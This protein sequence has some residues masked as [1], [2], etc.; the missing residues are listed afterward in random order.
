MGASGDASGSSPRHSASAARTASRTRPCVPQSSPGSSAPAL[1]GRALGLL[2]G[3]GGSLSYVVVVV[4]S[5]FALSFVPWVGTPHHHHLPAVSSRAHSPPVASLKHV[6]PPQGAGI[7]PSFASACFC[8]A[9]SSLRRL[10]LLSG[11]LPGCHAPSSP[12]SCAPPWPP[13]GSCR[14]GG[15]RKRKWLVNIF[16][17]GS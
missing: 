7:G 14:E 16:L 10:L 12:S 4:A 6:L 11:F 1:L 13:P 3:S 5:A 17:T 2:L 9:D 15:G 8:T